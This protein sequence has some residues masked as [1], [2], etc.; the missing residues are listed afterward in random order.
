MIC[1]CIGIIAEVSEEAL[2]KRHDQGWVCEVIDDLDLLV[3]R[4]REARKNKE[5]RGVIRYSE[6][7]YT[8]SVACFISGISCEGGPT[9]YSYLEG[10]ITQ[11]RKVNRSKRILQRFGERGS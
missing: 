5:V 1:G 11:M 3:K 6:F 8:S 7:R 2:R 10:H 9:L 4:V